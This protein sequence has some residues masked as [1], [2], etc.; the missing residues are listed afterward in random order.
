MLQRDHNYPSFKI[1]K[2]SIFSL[3]IFLW[4]DIFDIVIGYGIPF[5]AIAISIASFHESRKVNK[6]Q[7]RLNEMEEQI[8]K[9]ELEEKEKVREAANK[10]IVEARI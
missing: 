7:L 6:V 4:K 1:S 8:K 2:I 5:I 9:Y 10:S 3:F